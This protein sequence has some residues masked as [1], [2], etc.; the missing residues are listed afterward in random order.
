MK[1][2]ECNDYLHTQ[3]KSLCY[4][5]RSCQEACPVNCITM[6]EDE[7]TF[8]YPKIDKEQCLNCGMCSKVC[9]TNNPVFNHP[10]KAVATV[11]KD[12][13]VFFNSASGGAFSAVSELLKSDSV[14]F[15]GATMDNLKVKHTFADDGDISI[16]RKS[17]YVQSDTNGCFKLAKK[18]LKDGRGVVFSGTPCQIMALKSFLAGVNTEKLFTIDVICHGVPSQKMFDMHIDELIQ[19]NSRISDYIFKNKKSVDGK[20]NTRTAEIIYENG[21]SVIGNV[22]TDSF[23][24]AY[25]SRLNYRPSCM[26]CQFARRE[27]V[28]DLT[29]GDAWGI[30]KLY[31]NLN[32]RRGVSL[33][34]ANTKRGE[35]ILERLD[36]VMDIYPVDM[37]FAIS[38]NG[39]LKFPTEQ[40]PKREKFF[41][42]LQRQSFEKAVEDVL[43]VS[44]VKRIKGKV[45]R[46]IK[47]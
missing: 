4:G 30:E 29:I 23:L 14:V 6:V 13:D 45:K 36:S 39:Q 32:S 19:K 18:F 20:V 9:P 21:Q 10:R 8:F 34:M 2:V 22:A 15:F 16:F 3:N 5:C 43:R 24:K 41:K 35:E 27:R 31:S 26:V 44:L 38:T 7:E 47:R 17:K 46:I 1:I 12:E 28:S 37:E 11:H 40:H 33:V 42:L 25:Y